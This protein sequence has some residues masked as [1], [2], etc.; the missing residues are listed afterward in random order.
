MHRA[1]HPEGDRERKGPVRIGRFDLV[2]Q[3]LLEPLNIAPLE[4][5]G[6]W[7]VLAH[8]NG[9]VYFTTFFGRAGFVEPETGQVVRFGPETEGLNELALG[10]H[11]QVLST[12]Y[13]SPEGRGGSVVVLEPDG[14][15]VAEL[16][17]DPPVGYR[18]AAKSLAWDPD[19]NEIWVNTD[20]LPDA[21]GPVLYDARVLDALG[22]EM[23]RLDAPELQFMA[24]REDGTG[25]L[26]LLEGTVLSLA[27]LPDGPRLRPGPAAHPG[28]RDRGDSL[29]RP[30]PPPACR[31]AAQLRAAPP[32]AGRL[33][34]HRRDRGQPSL[35]HL[36]RRVDRGVP[37]DGLMGSAGQED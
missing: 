15:L 11:G 1:G 12:R 31:R 21:G 6:T 17:L 5:S 14:D 8:P 34:L 24:F 4:E 19:R 7:D 23:L 2:E 18:V 10:P 26:A 32:G 33:L 3:R 27:V 29:E 30:D 37:P 16:L 13:G 20:L 25:Y 28:R 36:L 35:R 22:H 9:R